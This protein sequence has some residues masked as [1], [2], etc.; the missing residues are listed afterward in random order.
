MMFFCF[1]EWTLI[2]RMQ[3]NPSF[4]RCTHTRNIRVSLIGRHPRDAPQP[5]I[6]ETFLIEDPR[7]AVGL[8]FGVMDPS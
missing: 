6:L 4:S 7:L 2:L 5:V 3:L 1:V 8:D